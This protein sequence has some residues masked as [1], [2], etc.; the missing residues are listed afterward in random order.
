M[1]QFRTKKRVRPTVNDHKISARLRIFQLSQFDDKYFSVPYI[2]II[3][4]V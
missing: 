4:E 2:T 3:V 1:L